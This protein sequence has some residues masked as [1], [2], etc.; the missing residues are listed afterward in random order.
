MQELYRHHR[1]RHRIAAGV[2]VKVKIR[3]ALNEARILILGAQVLIGFQYRAVLEPGFGTCR[4][5]HS[6]S[7]GPGSA[8]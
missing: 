2:H 6:G 3:Y 8:C 5:H 4:Q 7:A 1:G